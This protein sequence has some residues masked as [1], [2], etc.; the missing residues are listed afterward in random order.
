VF[1]ASDGFAEQRI[2]GNTEVCSIAADKRIHETTEASFAGICFAGF[3]EI[4]NQGTTESPLGQ[5]DGYTEGRS[6][7]A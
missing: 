1:H 5:Y 6:V 3:T 7:A 4:R 2:H